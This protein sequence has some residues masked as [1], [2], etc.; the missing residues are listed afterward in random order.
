MFLAPAK[1]IGQMMEMQDDAAW[2]MEG[3]NDF[4]FAL[5]Q[6]LTEIAN[7]L[8]RALSGS[9]WMVNRLFY[10]YAVLVPAVLLATNRLSIAL[11]L[12]FL[13]A[14]SVL[15]QFEVRE[16]TGIPAEVRTIYLKGT[17]YLAATQKRDG[18]LGQQ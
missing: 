1:Q 17:D 15:G 11:L 5:D 2:G 6:V 18:S 4:I 9:F 7:E 13:A 8:E 16:G 10:F 12:L 3:E 14:Q